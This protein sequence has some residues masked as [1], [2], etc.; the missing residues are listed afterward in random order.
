MGANGDSTVVLVLGVSTRKG[1]CCMPA[2]LLLWR[3]TDEGDGGAPREH[4]V[5]ST[6][7]MEKNKLNKQNKVGRS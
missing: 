6:L 3:M 5:F 1:M 4:G 7:L 2:Y